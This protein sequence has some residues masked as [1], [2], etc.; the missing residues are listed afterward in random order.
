MRAGAL[1]GAVERFDAFEIAKVG[2]RF[3]QRFEATAALPGDARISARG[4]H[5][6]G[7]AGEAK[8]AV[9]CT[10]VCVEPAAPPGSAATGHC[11]ALV[12]AVAHEGAFTEAPP[13]SLLIRAI[14]LAAERPE[15]ALSIAAAVLL[16]LVATVLARRPRPRP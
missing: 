13:P 7:F 12:D 6:L 9:L 4:R 14:L 5:M 10:V 2:Q 8:G 11:A 16:A 1:G 15:A 3:E